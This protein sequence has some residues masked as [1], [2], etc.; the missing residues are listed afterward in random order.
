M[1]QLICLFKF[2]LLLAFPVVPRPPSTMD[3]IVKTTVLPLLDQC[4][5]V[6]PISITSITHLRPRSQCLTL[7]KSRTTLE[8]NTMPNRRL[9]RSTTHPA[10]PRLLPR[11]ETHLL[12]DCPL[13]QPS[14]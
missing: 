3:P 6:L 7:S 5:L 4:L 8:K 1:A 9:L 11:L 14:L 12:N 2:L 13:S 10:S